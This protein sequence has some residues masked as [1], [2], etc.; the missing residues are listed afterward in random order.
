MYR[1]KGKMK[2]R[3]ITTATLLIPVILFQLAC[4]PTPAVLR[5]GIQAVTPAVE[6]AISKGL[7]TRERADLYR[8]D[9]T[10]LLNGYDVLVA[11]WNVA[12]NKAAKLAAAQTFA[13]STL[14][15]I[16]SDFTKV[17]QLAEAMLILNT[18]VAVIEAF[19]SGDGPALAPGAPAI[20]KTERE[21]ERYL[22]QQNEAL[23]L[24]L[25][26]K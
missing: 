14:A 15:P 20:P 9:A 23:K 10:K 22:K 5:V 19:Y 1:R 17:P 7:I 12:P 4:G 13:N 6:Y 18:A 26:V 3:S 24:A 2:L 21:M 16:A 25:A 11:A 8:G